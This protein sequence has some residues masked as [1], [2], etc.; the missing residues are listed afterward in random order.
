MDLND[1]CSN[2][3]GFEKKS[4]NEEKY[5]LFLVLDSDYTFHYQD[6]AK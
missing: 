6:F 3:G 1:Q 5:R 2:V 4:S